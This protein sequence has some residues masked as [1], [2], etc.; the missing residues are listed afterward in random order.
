MVNRRDGQ[1]LNKQP[2]VPILVSGQ[3]AK[4]IEAAVAF[5]TS[6]WPFIPSGAEL[7]LEAVSAHDIGVGDIITFFFHPGVSVTHRVVKVLRSMENI[8]FLTKGDNRSNLDPVVSPGQIAGRVVQVG[9]RDIRLFRW[10]ALGYTAAWISY[11]QALVLRRAAS[12]FLNRFRHALEDQGFLPRMKVR[13]SFGRLTN[14]FCWLPII[15][16]K[17]QARA[18]RKR[19]RRQGICVELSVRPAA[20]ETMTGVWNRAFPEYSTK[21]DRLFKWLPGETRIKS[22]V[23]FLVKSRNDLLGWALVRLESHDAKTPSRTPDGYIDAFALREEGWRNKAGQILFG[24]ILEW[25]KKNRVK[26]I[27]LNPHPV[28]DHSE[29]IPSTPL[30]ATASE[31]GFEP[32]EMSSEWTA[33]STDYHLPQCRKFPENV[34]IRPFCKQDEIAVIDFLKKNGQTNANLFLSGS[35]ST[36][37]FSGQGIF[38]A[39][40][41]QGVV[42]FCRYI[43]DDL[44]QDCRDITWVWALSEPEMKRGYFLRLLVDPAFRN[45]GIG[46]ALAAAAFQQLFDVGCR[47]ISLIALKS[48]GR[49]R[50]YGRFGFSKKGSFLKLRRLEKN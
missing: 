20:L 40:S 30:I 48:E 23:F 17:Y 28:A 14:P 15:L 10:R 42:G 32:D 36:P 47:Q 31:F 46:T 18:L 43:S 50:F 16:E 2:N 13:A 9:K 3:K 5:G 45:R 6:M 35:Q 25:L 26:Q 22:T 37:F 44:V 8:S 27:F 12:S 19:L 4:G 49:G 33:V 1:V 34:S 41:A 39:L 38:I 21:P 7:R 11:G 24:D 29:G